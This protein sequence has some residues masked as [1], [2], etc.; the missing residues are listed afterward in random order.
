MRERSPEPVESIIGRLSAT[1]PD[2]PQP[3]V[4]FRDLTPVFA[5]GPAL[6]SIVH[7]LIDPFAGQFDAV[8]GIEARG[9]LLAAAGAYA[10]G[11]GVV[12]VRKKGKLPRRVYAEDYTLEY[13]TATLELHMDDLRPG[14]RVLI[15]DDVL[16]TGGTLAAAARLFERAGVQVSG[17]GVVLELAGLRGRANL[18]GRRIRSLVRE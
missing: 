13:G 9:F 15:L 11:S 7:A 16:A 10:S 2:Y 18:A 12:T 6:R 8:A 1:V 3:G 4:V 5:D 14:M 17:F